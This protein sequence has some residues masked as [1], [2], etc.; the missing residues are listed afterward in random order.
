[1]PRQPNI[2]V[3]KSEVGE[4]ASLPL[5]VIPSVAVLQAKRGTSL[6]NDTPLICWEIPIRLSLAALGIAQGRLS[7]REA[8]RGFS[9]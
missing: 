4:T 5:E 6:R 3:G 7:A 1:M 8:K 9:G 2:G